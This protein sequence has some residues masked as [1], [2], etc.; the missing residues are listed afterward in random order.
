MNRNPVIRRGTMLLSFVILCERMCFYGVRAC[1]LFYAA[2]MLEEDFQVGMPDSTAKWFQSYAILL[3]ILPIPIGLIVDKITNQKKGV[4]IGG[5]FSFLGFLL[6]LIGSVNTIMIGVICVAIGT[7]F[8]KPSTIVLVGRQFVKSDVQRN[9]TF[10]L[11]FLA[12]N[13]GALLGVLVL[14]SIGETLGW[15]VSLV[16]AAG[17]TGVY[18]LVFILSKDVVCEVESD[19]IV[20]NSSGDKRGVFWSFVILM[21]LFICYDQPFETLLFPGLL[22]FR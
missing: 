10:I 7:S 18:T 5:V 12:I 8:I 16:L 1:L 19:T 20:K 22:F 3:L 6:M 4:V 11:Y 21:A 2:S 9:L 14:A 13:I 15:F 17:L